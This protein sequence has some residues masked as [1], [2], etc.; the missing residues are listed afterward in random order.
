MKVQDINTNEIFD[1]TKKGNEVLLAGDSGR[2]LQVTKTLF[3]REFGRGGC[4]VDITKKS[5][6][7][8]CDVC[9]GWVDDGEA[10][11]ENCE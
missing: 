4:L 6:P 5:N 3:K 1:V 9:G 10:V 11:C 2:T 8:S 7:T